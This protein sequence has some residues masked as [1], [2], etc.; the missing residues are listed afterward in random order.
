MHGSIVNKGLTN[1][2]YINSLTGIDCFLLDMDTRKILNPSWRRQTFC[3]MCGFY[4]CVPEAIHT[5]GCNEAYRLQETHSFYCPLGLT[6]VAGYICD[7]TGAL[8]GGIT[9]GPVVRETTDGTDAPEPKG[10]PPLTGL[11]V[12]DEERLARLKKLVGAVSAFSTEKELK[13]ASASYRRE[14]E[15]KKPVRHFPKKNRGISVAG[16]GDMLRDLIF[17]K[18]KRG[19]QEFTRQLLEGI[20]QGNCRDVGQYKLAAME[21]L[22]EILRISVE[23]GTSAQNVF[24]QNYYHIK[25]ISRFQTA[26]QIK[27]WILPVVY[28]MIDHAFD[29]MQERKSNII[30]HIKKYIKKQYRTKIT[31]SDI[32]GHVHLNKTYLSE[33]FNEETGEAITAYINRVRVIAG[34][35]LLRDTAYSIAEVAYRCGFEDQSYFTKVFKQITGIPPSKFRK[36]AQ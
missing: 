27:E 18:N 30:F 7:E 28:R 14:E 15:R 26:I 33:L 22:T 31:L 34:K 19:V 36:M 25:R 6:M 24:E 4:K 5:Y 16:Y 11:V 20:Y 32:A 13:Q 8:A 9:V 23:T 17:A 21:L 3:G 10:S 35:D 1:C 2:I 12:F 29:F